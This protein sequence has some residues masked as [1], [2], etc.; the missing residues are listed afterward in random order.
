MYGL[1][2]EDVHMPLSI[3]WY[4]ALEFARILS[5]IGMKQSAIGIEALWEE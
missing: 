3:Y 2:S 5:K 4:H 1:G